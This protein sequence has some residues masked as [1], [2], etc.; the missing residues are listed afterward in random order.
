VLATENRIMT[1]G[2]IGKRVTKENRVLERESH[3]R[4]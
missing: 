3:V 1:E 4:E 2:H